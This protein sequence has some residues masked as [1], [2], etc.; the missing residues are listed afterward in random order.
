[1]QRRR[2]IATLLF[3][4]LLSWAA[5][6]A[7]A[8][9]RLAPQGVK[10]GEVR[11]DSAIV[12]TRVAD[13][14]DNGVAASVRVQYWPIVE[15]SGQVITKLTDWHPARD[16]R[17]HT[18]NIRLDGLQPGT[19]YQ[20]VV[21]IEPSDS[22]AQGFVMASFRT[23]PAADQTSDVTFVVIGCQQYET[24]DTPNG[25]RVYETMLDVEPDFAVHTGDIVYY[26]KPNPVARS[27]A[28]ARAKWHRMYSQP[29]LMKFHSRVPTYFQQDDHDV[30]KDDSWTGQQAGE[31]TF[32]E[33]LAI[34][35]EQTPSRRVPYGTVRWGKDLQI[36][37][38]EGRDFRSP[39]NTPDGPEKTIL[40]GRQLSWLET[41]LNDSD[42]TFKVVISPTPIVGP[43]RDNKN[44]NHSNLGFKYEGDRLRKLLASVPS[45]FVVCGD[46]HWQYV[47]V[48]PVTGLREYSVGPTTD[49]HAGGWPQDKY[50][51][52][53]H[54]F[55]RV[56]GG[57]LS[58]QVTH[59]N[60]QPKLAMRHHDVE[61]TFVH[62]DV[63]PAIIESG[64]QP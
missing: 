44:D 58:A 24:R 35:D 29:L 46:R 11:Q 57:F 10:I 3:A 41:M 55:L 63:L 54:H 64:E 16:D 42:A 8:D 17:D 15:G 13:P 14:D 19:K 60:G 9:E 20:V 26:D 53:M 34:F 45:T 33:G 25:Q 38:L 51:E 28:A 32:A 36:W 40:G 43:D 31:L 27:V 62:E 7:G 21:E 47:S 4:A 23:A 56:K 49:K 5:G 59:E 52:N 22:G 18:V 12:W 1:M 2:Q 61:G 48:D 37:L 30:L 50:V 6:N 39:N